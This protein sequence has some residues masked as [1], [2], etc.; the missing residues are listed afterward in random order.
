MT[1]KTRF[2][3]LARNARECALSLRLL[4]G[5]G[6]LSS[7]KER[8]AGWE[9]SSIRSVRWSV[10]SVATSACLPNGLGKED[11]RSRSIPRNF[12]KQL[13]GFLKRK[14]TDPTNGK[15]E[16][17]GRATEEWRHARLQSSAP[18]V[19]PHRRALREACNEKWLPVISS[20]P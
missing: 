19:T 1:R 4:V 17:T 11:W 3:C 13:S 6:F 2:L 15:R 18:G 9:R 16:T 12:K 20:I 8:C 7:I 10:C 14:I 5:W